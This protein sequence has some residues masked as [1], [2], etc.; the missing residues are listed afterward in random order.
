MELPQEL[1]KRAAAGAR[2]YKWR[3]SG[4]IM[5]FILV[6]ARLKIGQWCKVPQG[7][8]SRSTFLMHGVHCW[9]VSA[10]GLFACATTWQQLMSISSLLIHKCL[11]RKMKPKYPGYGH[12]HVV[13]VTLFGARDCAVANSASSCPYIHPTSCEQ[14]HC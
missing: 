12:Y 14:R 10:F 3:A 11:R 2:M 6:V 13:L 7:S 8:V 5:R 1:K 4:E 9:C